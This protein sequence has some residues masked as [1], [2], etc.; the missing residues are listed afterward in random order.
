MSDLVKSTPRY[1]SLGG[2]LPIK[3]E[4]LHG[5]GASNFGFDYMLFKR[6]K[7]VTDSIRASTVAL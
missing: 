7:R 2:L 5:L 3:K 4:E 6:S 1:L